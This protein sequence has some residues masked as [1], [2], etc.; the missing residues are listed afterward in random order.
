ME[1]RGQGVDG[2]DWTNVTGDRDKWQTIWNT[3]MKL[4]FHSRQGIC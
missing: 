4:G 1:F 2:V 3:V